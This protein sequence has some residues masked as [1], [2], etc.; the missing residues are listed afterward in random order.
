MKLYNDPSLVAYWPLDGDAMDYAPKKGELER[1]RFIGDSNLV[2]YWKLND[3]S[4]SKGANTLTNNNGGTFVPALLGNGYDSGAYNSNKNLSIASNL[5]LTGNFTISGWFKFPSALSATYSVPSVMWRLNIESSSPARHLQINLCAAYNG[6]SPNIELDWLPIGQTYLQNTYSI[7]VGD[8]V[9]R[10]Y[11]VTYDGSALRLYLNGALVITD[12]SSQQGTTAWSNS[13][14]IGSNTQSQT[15][16][17][18][19][20]DVSVFTRAL[21]QSEAEEIYTSG[22]NGNFGDKHGAPTGTTV[23]P[24]KNNY[25]P[26]SLTRTF[27]GSSDFITAPAVNVFPSVTYSM[28]LYIPSLPTSGA[29]YQPVTQGNSSTEV[30]L[31]NNA[32]TQ[33]VG[34]SPGGSITYTLP[35]GR[36]FHLVIT[37][38]TGANNN[39]F[40]VNGKLVGTAT[41]SNI[42][43]DT[44]NFL[45][46]KH[47]SAGRYYNGKIQELAVF[48]RVLSPK[49]ISEYYTKMTGIIS[50][51]SFMSILAASLINKVGFVQFSNIK[52]INGVLLSAIKKIIGVDSVV[53]TSGFAI[54]GDGQ[55]TG[56]WVL[57]TDK[58]VYSTD[59]SSA[60]TALII[61][62]AATAGAGNTTYGIFGCGQL[63]NASMSGS[64]DKYTYSNDATATATTLSYAR[65]EVGA[66]GN[67]TVGVWGGGTNAYTLLTSKY[68]YSGETTA[69]GTS[70]SG[71]ARGYAVGSG[72]TTM[73]IFAGG[74]NGAY[75]SEVSKYT[76]SGDSVI[77][78]TALTAAR[79]DGCAASSTTL[80]V[81]AGGLNGGGVTTTKYSFSGNSWSAGTSLG[82]D[83][84]GS[85]ATGSSTIGIFKGTVSTTDK[86]T[87][88]GDTV[89]SGGAVTT[90]RGGDGCVSSTPSWS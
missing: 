67:A 64:A 7:N 6:G 17:C 88:S 33:I 34:F 53:T 8:N 62:R 9:W 3:V 26:A 51:K 65:M 74:H 83:R 42:T 19:Y 75:L 52:K 49:E 24:S 84:T 13:F 61:G 37:N 68:T 31:W 77:A 58:Y 55:I 72:D 43:S 16:G 12:T 41:G 66:A 73:G 15:G 1:T 20:D 28:M 2:S 81:Y 71:T 18:V 10:H 80:G 45:I 23:E 79:A 40:Y 39:R 82:A 86:Y 60:G 27:N 90:G 87:W 21:T 36:W 89:A 76:Y 78:G 4:D 29:L 46:G 70:L 56:A 48:N 30:Y 57:S 25:I 38:A 85:C 32:G 14:N 11:C 35:T 47:P 22:V 63:S 44:G 59:T 5:G 50:K 54:F 69:A